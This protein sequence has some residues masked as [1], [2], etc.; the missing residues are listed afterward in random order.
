MAE[1]VPPP[2]YVGRRQG[3]DEV[4]GE[5][6]DD[7]ADTEE[8]R[9]DEDD[10]DGNGDNGDDGDDGEEEDNIVCCFLTSRAPNPVG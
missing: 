6:D 5:E 8:E 10:T 4:D 2:K 7:A 3:T 9:E 1:T